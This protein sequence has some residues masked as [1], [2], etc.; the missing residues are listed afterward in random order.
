M[1]FKPRRPLL[2]IAGAA[3]FGVA[4]AVLKGDSTGPRDALGN[5]SAPWL[6]LPY[7]AATTTR[8]WA[9]GAVVGALACFAALVGFYV[10]EAFVLDLGGHPMLTNLRLTLGAGHLWYQVGIP[11]AAALGALGGAR[12]GP[13]PVVSALVVGLALVGEPLVVFAWQI[14]TGQAVSDGAWVTS[15]PALWVGEM[16]LG[17]A[18]AAWLLVG[19]RRRSTGADR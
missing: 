15:Y 8:G 18:L 13:R 3:A 10:A 1:T 14:G 6:L 2:A 5:V 12:V 4:V 7:L 11:G 19:H 16:A 17:A 9:R